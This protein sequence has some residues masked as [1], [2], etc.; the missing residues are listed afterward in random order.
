MKKLKTI[1]LVL[2]VVLLPITV[3][4]KLFDSVN[5]G[6]ITGEENGFRFNVGQ[7]VE[8]E[9]TNDG[10]TFLAGQDIKSKSTLSYGF[11][12]GETIEINDTIEKDLF[13]AGQ[14]ITINGTLS[15][16]VFVAGQTVKIGSSVGRNLYAAGELVDLRGITVNGNVKVGAEKL[17]ID[18]DT[19]ITG[20]LSINDDI[21][22]DGKLD[23]EKFNIKYYKSENY[24][25][26]EPSFREKLSSKVTDMAMGFI[27]LV[28]LLYVA[29]KTREKM[30][31]MEFDGA[32][33]IMTAFKGLV[34][35][36]VVPI[37]LIVSCLFVFTFPLAMLALGAYV[38]IM[39]VASLVGQY[40][41]TRLLLVKFTNNDSIL[42]AALSS[43]VGFGLIELI[44]YVGSIVSLLVFFFG[45]GLI[46]SLLRDN[47]TFKETPNAKV[48]EEKVTKKTTKKKN[49]EE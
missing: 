34:F 40:Y 43:V 44:P 6:K 4:A 45:V 26:T 32:D 38:V 36:V 15:R 31:E 14:T 42:L 7:T 23:K 39:C 3:N 11:Y 48:I 13:V 27:V 35:V 28:A 10:L 12:A 1:L 24:E 21:K 16:D 47:I 17:L 2:A 46:Y 33:Y 20:K 49:T 22:V 37:I 25:I 19:V 41:I 9:I 18:D 30:H 5:K 8:Q 29:S